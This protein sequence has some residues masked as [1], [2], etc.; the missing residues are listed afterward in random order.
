MDV[1]N[2]TQVIHNIVINVNLDIVEKVINV[3]KMI[4]VRY[5][6]VNNVF[7]GNLKNVHNVIVVS[8]YLQKTNALKLPKLNVM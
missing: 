1:N 5:K 6:T 4:H 2:V 8:N 7:L 3:I